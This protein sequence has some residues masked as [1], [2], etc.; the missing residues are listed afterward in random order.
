MR[1]LLLTIKVYNFTQR[2][3]QANSFEVNVAQQL[4]QFAFAL[5]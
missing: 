4:Q 1:E 3:I 5:L 2:Q